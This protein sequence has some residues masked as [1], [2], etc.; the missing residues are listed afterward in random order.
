MPRLFLGTYLAPKQKESLCSLF[1]GN[2]DLAERWQCRIRSVQPAKLHL[3]W[4]FL[5]EV[6]E[7]LRERLIEAIAEALSGAPSPGTMVLD[8]LQVWFVKGAPRHL[9]L[10]PSGVAS[11]FL[12]LIEHLRRQ[13]IDFVAPDYRAQAKSRFR[14]HVTLMRFEKA[15]K[16][17]DSMPIMRKAP[18][19]HPF[20]RSGSLRSKELE[21]DAIRGMND[22][23]PLYLKLGD[24]EL[25]E[26]KS[27][28]GVH[29]YH[30]L[31]IFPLS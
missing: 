23:L 20:A 17:A 31:N 5:G 30:S 10:T 13:L 15:D 29:S 28:K 21:S 7:S 19:Q 25:I 8:R 16:M 9:V 12:N 3:T 11:E 4:M 18:D 22:V 27:E 2:D 14:P 6:E 26:S 1:D 24:V